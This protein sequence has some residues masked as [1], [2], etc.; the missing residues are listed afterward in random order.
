MPP[1]PSGAPLIAIIPV[2]VGPLLLL[3]MMFPVLFSA[4]L[5]IRRW[6]ALWCVA[7]LSVA[8]SL[9]QGW[10]HAANSDAWWA[11]PRPL[12]LTLALVALAGAL[13]AGRR[14]RAAVRAGQAATAVPR[15]ELVVLG[16]A[17][18]T[19]L[20]MVGYW[21]YFRYPLLHPLLVVWVAAWSGTL[22]VL[23]IHRRGPSAKPVQPVEG[24]LLWS[25]TFAWAAFAAAALYHDPAGGPGPGRGGTVAWTFAADGPGS[26][27]SS[28]LVAGDRVYAAAGHFGALAHSGAVYC[29]DRA[30]GRKLWSFDDHGTLRPVFSSP[31][32]AGGR[33][34]FGEGYHQD[35]FCRLF[36][37]DAVTGAKLWDFAT[38]SH[39]ESS[40]CVV[41]GKVFFGA[42]ADGIYCL[43]ADNGAKLWHFP[44]P[45]VDSNPAV[46]EDRLYA[47]SGSGPDYEVFCLDAETGRRIWRA[48]A[49]LPVWGAPLVADGC[50]WVGLGTGTFGERAG[51]PAGALLCLDAH[52]GRRVWRYDV[53]DSVLGKPALDPDRVYFCSLDHQCYCLDRKEGQLCWR[54]DLGSPVMAAPAL[55]GD[56]LYVAASGGRVCRLHAGSGAVQWTVDLARLSQARPRLFSSPAVVRADADDSRRLYVGAG[57][58]N[59]L[60]MAALLYC[61]EDRREPR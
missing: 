19:G 30:T 47:G 32:L 8:L 50:V 57:L 14:H 42:G 41:A 46:V 25:A 9:A 23:A 33:L 26:F 40:P 1:P 12:W 56:S 58:D 10:Y 45:H 28:P 61:L 2:L 24:V 48:A 37:L 49:D 6:L 18:L 60:R 36:C 3:A 4:L 43:R 52:T 17:S 53:G 5:V 21:L 20:V 29:L 51:R 44:G 15:S 27:D 55:A 59:G 35:S 16:L 34:Y 11:G 7:A 31:C 54:R 38:A 22:Y 39:T 13:W